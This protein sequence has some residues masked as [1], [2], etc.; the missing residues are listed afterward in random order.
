[1]TILVMKHLFTH[2]R[3][4][5]SLSVQ[6]YHLSSERRS[7]AKKIQNFILFAVIALNSSEIMTKIA[8]Y[9]QH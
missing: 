8:K 5:K 4:V 7:L 1:M 3:L 6:L 9:R 2:V